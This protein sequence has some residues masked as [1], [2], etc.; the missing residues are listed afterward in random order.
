MLVF[1]AYLLFEFVDRVS[2]VYIATGYGIGW[3]GD[4][5]PVEAMFSE[6]VQI[7]P[8]NNPASCTMGI[9]SFPRVKR[10]VRGD[11]HQ[12]PSSVEVNL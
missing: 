6:P 11:G 1:W 3:P 4:R 8:G 12:P 2:S 10:P 9:G 7:G 5:I